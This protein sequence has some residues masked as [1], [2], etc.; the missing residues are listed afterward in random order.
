MQGITLFDVELHS[1]NYVIKSAQ[2][3]QLKMP[4]GIRSSRSLPIS[5]APLTSTR[6]LSSYMAPPRQLDPLLTAAGPGFDPVIAARTGV[7]LPQATFLTEVI[8]SVPGNVRIECGYRGAWEFLQSGLHAASAKAQQAEA[9]AQGPTTATWSLT[10]GTSSFDPE[11]HGGDALRTSSMAEPRPTLAATVVPRLGSSTSALETQLKEAL[12][13]RN[14]AAAGG[15]PE[16]DEEANL[17]GDRGDPAEAPAGA[18]LFILSALSDARRSQPTVSIAPPLSVN[19]G[20]RPM[21]LPDEHSLPR[22]LVPAI[23]K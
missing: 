14:I 7:A 12:L 22:R 19:R 23:G 21:A 8:P 4:V 15:L 11:N 1:R 18:S 5:E 16:A 3:S 2:R 10:G 17:T 6:G 20:Q 13:S 9:A